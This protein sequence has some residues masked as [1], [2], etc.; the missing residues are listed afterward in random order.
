MVT[1]VD[2]TEENVDDIFK[3]CSYENRFNVKS[4]EKGIQGK[5]KW[6]TNM[7]KKHG[8]CAKITYLGDKPAAQ[9][10]YY[11]EEAVPYIKNPRKDVV[12]LHCIY[13]SAPE[14]QRKGVASA[15]MK[16]FINECITDI[17]CL[18]CNACSFLVTQIFPNE[19]ELSLTDFYARFGFKQGHM[20]M[21]RE[22]SEDYSSRN[23]LEY[24]PIKEDL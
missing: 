5:R 2:V 22:V 12:F 18:G 9:I 16:E 14:A 13:N 4:N 6:L 17:R 19:G 15:L 20:E 8:P 11:P 23:I 7:L 10:T 1:I 21:F 3:I 24:K